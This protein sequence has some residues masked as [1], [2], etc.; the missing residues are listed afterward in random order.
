MSRQVWCRPYDK[1]NDRK[2][3]I[4][5]LYS[6]RELNRFD[7][8]MLQRDQV[9]ISTLFDESGIIGFVVAST[10]IFLEYLVFRP[11][12]PDPT[13]A[14]GLQAFQHVLV[15]NATGKNV[16][17]AYFRPSDERYASFAKGYGW[18]EETDPMLRLHFSGLEGHTDADNG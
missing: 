4:E 16:P 14:K 5:W 2:K 9:S 18:I 7:P 17:D 12:L 3:F 13:R 11:D 10:A 8:E 6:Q 1:V 15:N